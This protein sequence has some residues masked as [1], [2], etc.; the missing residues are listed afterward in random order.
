VIELER[1]PLTEGAELED[2]GFG[3]DYELLATT[4]SPRKF[5]VIGRVEEGEGVE[6]TLGGE[7]YSLAGWEHF[8]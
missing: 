6:L 5:P 4:V 8:R 7:P 1:V 3:E 2:V